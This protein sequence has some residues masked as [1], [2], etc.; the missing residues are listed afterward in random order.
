VTYFFDKSVVLEHLPRLHDTNNGGLQV[1]LAVLL[2]GGTGL[3]D[4]LRSLLLGNNGNLEPRTL[5]R[6][7]LVEDDDRFRVRR[8]RENETK[9][10]FKTRNLA[11]VIEE[12]TSPVA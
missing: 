11:R 7:I 1:Q 8:L 3:F 6:V 12:L 9:L 4:F 5:V 2:D 10:R